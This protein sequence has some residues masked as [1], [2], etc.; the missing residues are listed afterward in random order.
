MKGIKLMESEGA[1][2]RNNKG[3]GRNGRK[4]QQANVEREKDKENVEEE[5]GKS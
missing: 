2:S 5:I 1:W 4:E 3:K